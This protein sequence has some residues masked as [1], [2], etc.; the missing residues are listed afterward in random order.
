MYPS[1][2]RNG[3]QWLL[4]PGGGLVN[5]TGLAPGFAMRT[6]P[7]S[8]AGRMR[9]QARGPTRRRVPHVRRRSRPAT[10]LKRPPVS[11]R[12]REECDGAA[13]GGPRR[14][15]SP[16]GSCHNAGTSSSNRHSEQTGHSALVGCNEDKLRPVRSD[17]QRVRERLPV[18]RR[19]VECTRDRLLWRSVAARKQSER[20]ELASKS[21][22]AHAK[23][24]P[25]EIAW[26]AMR[27]LNRA[28]GRWRFRA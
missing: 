4:F 19:D 24:S 1:G 5:E 28:L 8:G 9:F 6:N 16:V 17:G 27:R 22:S 2:K 11:A 10:H 15:T 23:R 13:V 21:P 26:S 14:E 3:I 25:V 20:E 7:M 12:A 18:R